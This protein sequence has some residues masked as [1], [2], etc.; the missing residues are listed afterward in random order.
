MVRIK[1]ELTDPRYGACGPGETFQGLPIVESFPDSLNV[2]LDVPGDPTA[3]AQTM[4]RLVAAGAVKDWRLEHHY[5]VLWLPRT[6][7]SYR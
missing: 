1:A 6:V 5:T 7:H 2:I 3:V 4:V